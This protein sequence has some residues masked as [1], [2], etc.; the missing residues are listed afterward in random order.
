MGNI[1]VKDGTPS[2]SG[3]LCRTCSNAILIRGYRES[4]QITLCEKPYQTMT[5]PFPVYEC[6]GYYDK[7]RPGW[8]QMEKLAINV[9]PGPLKPVGFKVGINTEPRLKVGVTEE[10]DE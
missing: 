3:S 2:G 6:S 7:N 9:V 10:D 5:L 1:F 8:D 4:E